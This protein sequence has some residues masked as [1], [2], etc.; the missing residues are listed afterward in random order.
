LLR[1]LTERLVE[2]EVRTIYVGDLTGVIQRT[3]LKSTNRKLTEFWAHRRFTGRLESLC[4]EHGIELQSVSEFNS[5]RECPDCG[6]VTETYRHRERLT[7]SCGY[8]GHADLTAARTIL[9]RER[10]DRPR[11]MARPVRF[12][13]DNHRWRSTTDVPSWTNPNEQRT[14]P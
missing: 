2:D 9:N 4:E 6:S 12:Q 13:W 1:D 10:T 3:P 14:N 7:C 8:D 5:S 11:P